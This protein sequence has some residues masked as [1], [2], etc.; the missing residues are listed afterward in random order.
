MC[1]F[2]ERVSF[3][4]MIT[5]IED[6]YHGRGGECDPQILLPSLS[7]GLFGAIIPR[8]TSI[9]TASK[10]VLFWPKRVFRLSAI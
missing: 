2:L 10:S 4:I 5:L 8:P 7:V 9:F 1:S 6:R 3:I